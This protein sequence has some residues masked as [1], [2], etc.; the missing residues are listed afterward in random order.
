MVQ[1]STETASS[2][3]RFSEGQRQRGHE[4]DLLQLDL[5]EAWWFIEDGRVPERQ[6]SARHAATEAVAEWIISNRQV[7]T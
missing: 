6:R 2:V 7:S 4:V 1:L 3:E 5:G